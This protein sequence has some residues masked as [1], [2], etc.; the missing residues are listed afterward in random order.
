[1]RNHSCPEF[2]SH[3]RCVHCDP[4]S[5][6]WVRAL[7]IVQ[8]ECMNRKKEKRC[9][10]TKRGLNRPFFF[11]QSITK[12]RDKHASFACFGRSER[13]SRTDRPLV[14]SS[15]ATGF[16]PGT[17]KVSENVQMP[18]EVAD[19]PAALE[20]AYGHT[21]PKERASRCHADAKRRCRSLIR[22]HRPV[23]A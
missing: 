22:C 15:L 9:R 14:I 12:W 16:Q 2:R 4:K 23:L 8:T 18:R 10:T 6:L 1:M 3:L 7:K 20:Q 21:Y 11:E 19:F 5:S 13:N 17:A